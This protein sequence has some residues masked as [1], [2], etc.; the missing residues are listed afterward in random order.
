M[1]EKKNILFFRDPSPTDQCFAFLFKDGNQINFLNPQAFP[2]FPLPTMA[3]VGGNR[4][5]DQNSQLAPWTGIGNWY[6]CS[7]FFTHFVNCILN[8][9]RNHFNS[10]SSKIKGWADRKD[11]RNSVW[12]TIKSFKRDVVSAIRPKWMHCLCP[13]SLTLSET[14]DNILLILASCCTRNCKL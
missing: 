10:T 9:F 12:I 8:W 11:C 7:R 1:P 6:L 13:I 5:I 2:I 14:L 3:A 4:L